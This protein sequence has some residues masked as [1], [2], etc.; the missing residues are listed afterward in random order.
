MNHRFAGF[1]ED[2]IILT[3]PTKPAKPC[4]SSLH[5]PA[6]GQDFKAHHIVRSLYDLQNPSPEVFCPIHQL[7]RVSAVGPNSLEAGKTITQLFQNQ[8]ASVPI[9]DICGVDF[10]VQ[11]QAQRVDDDMPLTPFDFLARVVP[12]GAPFSVVLALWLS[13]MAALGLAS[14]PFFW[15]TRSRKAS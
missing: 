4:K 8:F 10:A 9:L 15:R 5:N 11:D 2:L 1:D 7:P 14:R 3:Q 12:S 6:M 13:I